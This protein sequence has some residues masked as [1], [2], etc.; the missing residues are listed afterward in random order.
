MVMKRRSFLAVGSVFSMFSPLAEAERQ[1]APRFEFGI[2]QYTF[3]NPIKSGKLSVLDYPLHCK[4]GLGVKHIEYWSGCLPN[5]EDKAFCGELKKRAEGEG[6]NNLLI[7]VDMRDRIDAKEEAQRK[8]SLEAHKKWVD[9]ARGMGCDAI[10]INVASGG[11]KAENMKHA[12]AGIPPLL[13]HAKQADVEILLENHGGNSGDGQW[14]ATLMRK[15]DHSHFGTLPD[16]GNFRD[17]DRY[18]GVREMMP[19]AGAVCAKS[20]AF[21]DKGN[22]KRIDYF[23]MLKIV[24]GS[25]YRGPISIEYEGGGD[26]MAGSVKTRDLVK[27]A[28]EAAGETIG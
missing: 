11:D 23:N 21:D 4:K 26:P 12:V 20:H 16:F 3:R 28:V 5:F 17:Y 1:K 2:Q 27:R 10:R 24:C 15:L 7:L 19:W 18:K 22:E 8:R 9:A 25:P 14:V 13:S 6:L